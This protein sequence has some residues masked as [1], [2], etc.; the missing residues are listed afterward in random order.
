[1]YVTP[2]IFVGFQ[3][4]YFNH[5]KVIITQHRD[6]MFCQSW[7]E[8]IR[9]ESNG[10][11]NLFLCHKLGSKKFG[12]KLDPHVHFLSFAKA[13]ALNKIHKVVAT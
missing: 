2:I 13:Q 1:M 4:L 10:D 12:P 11:P 5:Y 9:H 3:I 7:H 6:L 8:K